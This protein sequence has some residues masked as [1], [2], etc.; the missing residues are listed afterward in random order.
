MEKKG[1]HVTSEIGKLQSVLLHR[2]GSE[3]NNLIPRYLENLLFDEIPWLRKAQEEHNGFAKSIKDTGTKVFYIEDLMVELIQD[4]EVKR[5]LI[6]EHLKFSLQSDKEVSKAVF[7][8]LY[9]LPPEELNS[10]LLAGIHK[11]EVQKLKKH[12]TLSDLTVSSYPFY[13]DPM[14]SMYF[15]R[16]HGAMIANKLLVS[17][18]FNFARRRETIFLRFLQKHHKLFEN[19]KLWFEEEIPRGIEGGD[20]L[21]INSS[22]LVI[23]LSERTT[24]EAIEYITQKFIIETEQIR[25][26]VVIQIPAKRA[27]MHLDTVFTMIDYDKFLMYPGVKDDIHVYLLEKGTK[28]RIVAT[29]DHKLDELLGRYLG[30]KKAQ[31]I[32]SGGH[33]PITATREQWGDST[34]TLAIKPGV[35][36]CYNRNEATNKVLRNS[37]VEVV[38]IEGSEL[39][40]GR[41][42][43]RC[44]SMPL[45]RLSL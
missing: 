38:E 6:E 13:L 16:D 27:F 34:N 25:Q 33:E 18:M 17:S 40:R 15:T 2:P 10:K 23:G 37:G 5:Q 44:M 14:P 39:V 19:T 21:V 8:F 28:E 20:I 11:K 4:L 12:R 7:E 1:F 31:L 42:G 29:N 3:L 9:N 26:I 43:P 35:V 32:F 45:L 36:I 24:E 30:V 41:G 22:T